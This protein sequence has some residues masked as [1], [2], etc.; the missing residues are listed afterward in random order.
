M[1]QEARFDDLVQA[2][3]DAFIKVNNMSEAQHL[4]K[5]SDYFNSDST[6]KTF[7]ISYP[8][9][10]GE[11]EVYNKDIDVPAICLLPMSSLK[12]DEV[13]VDFKVKLYGGVKLNAEG[14]EKKEA[15]ATNMLRAAKKERAGEQ[16]TFIGY[17]PQGIFSKGRDDN[18]ANIRLKFVSDEPPEGLMRIQEQYTKISL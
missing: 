2:I 7:K 1:K 5:I 3:Q 16:G 4:K 12:L 8:M 9:F 13:E 14:E 11:G 18:Y 10:D 6:P 17:V 15:P